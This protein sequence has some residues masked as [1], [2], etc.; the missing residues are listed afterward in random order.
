MAYRNG[1]Y[2]H[3]AYSYEEAKT[4]LA[5]Y[6][7]AL[8]ALVSGQAKEYT[9]GSRSVTLLDVDDLTAMVDKFAG[10]VSK[11]EGNSRP[12]RSVAVVFRDT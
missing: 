8:D 1:K 4:Y 7:E 3:A 9:I 12:A 10:I 5:K 11:Y 2:Y 6:K